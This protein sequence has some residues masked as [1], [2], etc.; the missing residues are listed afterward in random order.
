MAAGAS[1]DR[2]RRLQTWV[3]K[4]VTNPPLRAALR[5]GIAP[6][7][8]A[9]LET[10]GRKTGQ[11]RLTPVGNGLDG[12]VFWLVSEKGRRAGYV[13]NLLAEPRVRVKVGRRWLSGRAAVVE[14][15]DGW[16]RRE[17]I[18]ARNGLMGR[19]DGAVFRASAGPEPVTIR[20]DL[21]DAG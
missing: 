1:R 2:R 5:L 7:S 17:R 15:D 10:T 16:A 12:R 13:A 20:I 3:E 9:L 4:H 6:R 8:F 18:D 19:F 21:D 11:R 14:G